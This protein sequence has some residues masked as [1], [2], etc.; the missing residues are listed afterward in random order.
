MN[1]PQI[2]T[3]GSLSCRVRLRTMQGYQKRQWLRSY[4]HSNK[5]ALLPPYPP[6]WPGWTLMHPTGGIT[7]TCR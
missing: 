7:P 5:L 1:T 3:S 6:Q 2:A 4:L